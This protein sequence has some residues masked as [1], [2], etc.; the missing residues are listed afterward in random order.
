MEEKERE[1]QRLM[2]QP[3]QERQQEVA[4]LRRCVAEKERACAASDILCRSLA[5]ETRQLRRTLAA[6]AHMCQ[7]LAQCLEERQSAQGSTGQRSPEVGRVHAGRGDVGGQGRGTRRPW[8]LG[9]LPWTAASLSSQ[10]G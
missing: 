9:A 8:G 6:T 3:G 5:E 10:G 7:H 1:T 4:L 2:S